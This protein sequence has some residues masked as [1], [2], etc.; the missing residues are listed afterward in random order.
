M[1]KLLIANGADIESEDSEQMTAAFYAVASENTDLVDYFFEK[2]AD[3]EHADCQN[4]TPFYWAC[5]EC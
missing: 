5:C 4:R 3:Y 2:G 1:A